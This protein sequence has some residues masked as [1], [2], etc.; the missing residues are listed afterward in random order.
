[1]TKV[2]HNEAIVEAFTTHR[3]FVTCETSQGKDDMV[4]AIARLLGV[5]GNKLQR[6]VVEKLKAYGQRVLL[7]LDNLE[8]A[9][10]PNTSKAQVEELLSTFAYLDNLSLVITMRGSERPGKVEWSR[11]FLPPLSPLSLP[12][13]R[14]A[15]LAV[16]DSAQDDPHVEEL[17]LAVDC[18]PLPLTLMATMAQTDTTSSLLQRWRGEQSALL[19]QT[20]DRRSNLDVSIQISLNSPRLLAVPE[21]VHLLALLSLLPDGV[22]NRKVEAIFKDINMPRRALS[23]LWRT[24]L[25]YVAGNNRT[26]V[27]A[28]IR[29]HMLLHHHPT[30]SASLN[31]ALSYYMGFVGIASELGRIHGQIIVE[32]MTPDVGNFHSIIYL[33]LDANTGL[34]EDIVRGGIGAAIDLSRFTRYTHLGVIDTMRAAR[35]AAE[36]LGD[37]ALL[38]KATFHLAWLAVTLKTADNKEALCNTAASLFEEDGNTFDLAGKLP[39]LVFRSHCLNCQTECMWLLGQAVKN[40]KQQKET[41]ERALALAVQSNNKLCQVCFRIAK[42]ALNVTLILDKN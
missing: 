37:N 41:R 34:E 23:T 18:V 15:F 24:S 17:L 33:A 11:P 25:A 6:Q 22:D 31:S 39:C 13:A 16:S 30:K 28:P 1:M 12:D 42:I 35:D 4:T 19:T 40:P 20:H 14:Q 38:A 3:F 10:E 8:T 2:L 9:W 27:L 29:A 5:Q 21:A 7:V 32:R 36:R 26:H